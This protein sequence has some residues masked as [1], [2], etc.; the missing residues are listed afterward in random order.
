LPAELSRLGFKRH[1]KGTAVTDTLSIPAFTTV[2]RAAA[3]PSPWV[4][5]PVWDA[6]FIQNA[7]WLL[8]V[9]LW[10][11][12][13]RAGALDAFY[14]ALT[15]LFWIGHR[16]TSTWLAYTTQAYRPLLKA[17][18]IRFIAVPVLVTAACFAILLPPDA[19][20]PWTR[21]ERAIVLAIVDYAFNTWHFGAQHFGALSLYRGRAGRSA[22][23][24]T[25][26][27]DRL[28]ALGIGGALIFVAD[29]L[30]GSVAY[31]ER[32]LGALPAWFA[33]EQ[34]PIRLCATAL[35]IAATTAM[36]VAEL[37]APRPSLPR[38]LYVLGLAAMVAVALQPRSLF[39][40]LAIWTSQ[41]W[42]L[43]VGLG[44][45]TPASEPAPAQGL[46]TRAL[47]ALNTRPWLLIALLMLLSVI[48]LPLF[49]VEANWQTPGAVWYGD[50]LFGAL[51]TGLRTSA[52]VPALLALGFATGFTHYLLDRAVYRFSDP[53]VRAAAAALMARR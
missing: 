13:V 45:Q 41:H 20:L 23:R 34:H 22:S 11:A 3:R 4:R 2:A 36:L 50:R 18:P 1:A 40:F 33:A 49:E 38:I 5:G 12:Q 27:I 16:L 29:L 30:A 28:F 46:L 31:P 6:V 21:G 15:A 8:P 14:F 17:Q 7:L 52:W 19:A 35:L 53:D 48:L 25:R 44:A 47:H 39:L 43:A 10:L 9:V 42:I 26:R 24:T 51:A 32:W 37:R